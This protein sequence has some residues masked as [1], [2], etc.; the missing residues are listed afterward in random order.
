MSQR[1]S[2]KS[3]RAFA[4]QGIFKVFVGVPVRFRE[5]EGVVEDLLSITGSLSEFQ[6]AF[7]EL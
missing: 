1:M 5:S 7:K 3:Q 4:V 2:E 6:R